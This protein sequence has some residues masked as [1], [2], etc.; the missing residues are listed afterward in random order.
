MSAFFNPVTGRHHTT[1]QARRAHDERGSGH[2][3]VC[4]IVGAFFISN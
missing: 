2:R 4:G 3:V 1:P